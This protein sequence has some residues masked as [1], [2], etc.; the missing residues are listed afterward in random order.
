MVSI[1]RS[2]GLGKTTIAKQVYDKIG[3]QFDSQAFISVC[4]RPALQNLLRGLKLKLQMADSSHA[5]EL[6]DIID[7]SGGAR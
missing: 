4:Q 1:L 5:H 3:E 6:Q 2:G 7:L